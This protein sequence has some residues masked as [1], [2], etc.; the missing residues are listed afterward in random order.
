LR[1][2]FVIHAVAGQSCAEFFK[3]NV[4]VSNEPQRR[5]LCT[6]KPAMAVQSYLL[7]LIYKRVQP[8]EIF[9]KLEPVALPV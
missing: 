6:P 2:V 7:Q 8:V 5:C 4:C 9:P 1:D 3:R